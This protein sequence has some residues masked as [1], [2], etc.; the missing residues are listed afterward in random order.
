MGVRTVLRR[1]GASILGVVDE[2]WAMREP[3]QYGHRPPQCELI[4]DDDDDAAPLD[5]GSQD[6]P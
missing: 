1:I 4:N 6:R 5:Q 2:Y 3:G